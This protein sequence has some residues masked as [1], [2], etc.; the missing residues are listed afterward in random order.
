MKYLRKLRI[1]IRINAYF[2]ITSYHR[3][4]KAAKL[5][6]HLSNM[7]IHM[8]KMYDFKWNLISFLVEIFMGT[9]LTRCSFI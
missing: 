8:M 2:G 4:C 6:L 1:H 5:F 9:H 3:M 7:K